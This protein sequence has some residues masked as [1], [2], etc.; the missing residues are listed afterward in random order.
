MSQKTIDSA[1]RKVSSIRARTW[2][3]TIAIIVCL[4][5]YLMVSLVKKEFDVLEFILMVFIQIVIHLA[6]FPDGELF[7]QK[8]ET[9]IN[10]RAM[11][12]KKA[13]IVNSNK[14]MGKLHEYCKYEFEVR[15]QNYIASMCSRAG[16]TVEDLEIFKQKT[17][18]ELKKLTSIE[19][20]GRYIT[21]AKYQI[22]IISNL[23]HKEIPVQENKASTIMSAIETNEDKAIKDE[24][25]AYRNTAHIKKISIALFLGG[26]FAL[27]GYT[28]RQGFGWEQVAS[29]AMYITTILTTAVL[30]FTSGE[31]CTKVHKNN[32]YLR[33]INF[34]SSFFE[35]ANIDENGVANE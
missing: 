18:K 15:K 34:L 24:S 27:I 4:L 35:W 13:D 2:T 26:F 16:I 31:T 14:A 7:G 5:L 12:N 22:K 30:A 17:K 21:F 19:I 29:I 32:F 23:I 11:Y 8:N 9:F 3:I 10:N 20:D 33:L 28:L 1:Y 6:Y 25:I